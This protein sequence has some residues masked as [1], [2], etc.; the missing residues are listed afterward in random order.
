MNP[1][2]L[3]PTP[4]PAS[5]PTLTELVRDAFDAYPGRASFRK[6]RI[7]VEMNGD[8]RPFRLDLM[9]ALYERERDKRARDRAWQ[10][11]LASLPTMKAKKFTA[12]SKRVDRILGDGPSGPERKFYRWASELLPHLSAEEERRAAMVERTRPRYGRTRT[13]EEHELFA[14]IEGQIVAYRRERKSRRRK[15]DQG[16]GR[17]S[18]PPLAAGPVLS[19]GLFDQ[20]TSDYDVPEMIARLKAQLIAHTTGGTNDR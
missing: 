5:T 19:L 1:A 9:K 10:R 18:V 4:D 6:V 7:Y 2:P 17:G 14:D 11:L 3:V 12:L 13:T 16:S 15:V 20:L 8:E